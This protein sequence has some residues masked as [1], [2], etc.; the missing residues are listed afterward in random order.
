M[1]WQH[2]FINTNFVEHNRHFVS[3]YFLADPFIQ[4][5]IFYKIWRESIDIFSIT[6]LTEL[7]LKCT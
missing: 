6:V 1:Y 5:Y 4:P 2:F 3:T 7:I